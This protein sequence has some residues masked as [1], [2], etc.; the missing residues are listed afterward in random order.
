MSN[1]KITPLIFCALGNPGNKY[2]NTRHNV[3]WQFFANWNITNSL[4]WTIKFKG[5]FA[6][7]DLNNERRYFIIPHTYMNL[8][9]EAVQPLMAF[10]KLSAEN[11]VV[12]QDELDLPV[13]QVEFK[14]G[15]GLAGHNGLKS[16]AQLL[17]TQDFIRVRIGIG[18]PLVG[19]VSDWVL[20]DFMGDEKI[21]R[22]RVFKVLEGSMQEWIDDNN[23]SSLQT[24]YN[25]KNLL[26]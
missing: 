15:G 16:I 9:G 17:G 26:A 23:F 14:N 10:F 7:T 1:K 19:S 11:L 2:K 5:E 25:K 24:K 6:Q 13:G 18:R 4:N 20:S 8:S 12:F 22:D 21:I 3:A